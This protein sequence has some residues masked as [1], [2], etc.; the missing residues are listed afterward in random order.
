MTTVPRSTLLRSLT[1]RGA[2][3][4]MAACMAL[5][6]AQAGAQTAPAPYPDPLA[7]KLQSDPRKPPR[8]HKFDRPG[9]VKLGPPATFAPPASGA[10][11]TGFDSQQQPQEGARKG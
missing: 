9:L 10:G 1:P 2:S 8:F 11:N 7:P 3:L 5:W 4:I 6:G